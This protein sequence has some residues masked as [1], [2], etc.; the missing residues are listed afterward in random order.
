MLA[1]AP[2]ANAQ[3]SGP[4]ALGAPTTLDGPNNSIVGLNGMSVARD[5]TGGIAYLEFVNGAPHV[6]ASRLVGGV[7]RAPEQLDASLGGGSSQAVI[8]ASSGGL[9]LVAF[10][11]SGSLYVVSRPSAS[12]GWSQPQLLAG[13]A[14]NPAID[15]NQF[16]KA[17]L[18]F[19]VGGGGASNV[20]CAYYVSGQ[21]SV[22][23]A[24]LDARPSA[25]AGSGQGR[26]RVATA[27]D[28]IGIVAWGEAGH[29][30]T[31]RVWGTSPSVVFQQADV[32]NVG[33]FNE[34][35]AN[36]PD[37]AAGGNSSWV[38][39]VFAE[40]LQ[41]GIQQQ[42][43]VLYN[44][45]Q[46]GAYNGVI[47]ADG[48]ATPGEAA[49]DPRIAMAEYGNGLVTSARLN[50]N[51]VWSS[52][53]LQNGSF[54]QVVRADSLT[55]SS[56]PHAVPGVV[57]LNSL[58]L[59]WQHDPG[60]LGAS[61]IR[62]RFFVVGTGLAPEQ[63]LSTPVW[64]PT[65][66]GSGIADGGDQNGDVA[67]AWVQGPPGSQRIVVAQ[68]YQP[69]DKPTSLSKYA[70]STHPQLSWMPAK[71]S[72]GPMRYTV[73]VDGAVVASTTA[74]SITVPVRVRKGWHTWTVTA[75]NPAG[76]QSLGAKSKLLIE[77]TRPRV[78]FNVT[79]SLTPGGSVAINLQYT[80][81]PPGVR[82]SS[83]VGSVVVRWGDGK[84]SHVPV[85]Q[86]RKFH[87]YARRGRYRVTV[88][89]TDRAKN[90]TRHAQQITIG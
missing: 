6:L 76:Q 62:A 73:R 18:A 53:L 79:G 8:A 13:G 47:G 33:A 65:A 42:T 12:K 66:A 69:P 15:A 10:I 25:N 4:P 50:S 31:R 83:G 49:V 55:N 80:D 85:G 72:W 37:V 48:S 88:I 9:L 90:E 43:R 64:G 23:S 59:A 40:T 19:T 57:G 11:N 29:I 51:Q 5:G 36:Q 20:R 22:E 44:R 54:A 35:S 3:L 7:F 68:M 27:G 77:T 89:V 38:G 30:Y 81:R 45:L 21:W 52:V 26:P 74:T 87:V 56:A 46:G 75:T 82:Y 84:S 67:V 28:G 86:P 78:N 70:R 1:W 17:Y 32:S 39:V 71:A 63:V 58:V 14:S 60:L 34:V 2:T 16:G 61:E 41:S 24:P